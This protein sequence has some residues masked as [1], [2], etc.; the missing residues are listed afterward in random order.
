[1]IA[2]LRFVMINNQQEGEMERK[3]ENLTSLAIMYPGKV[4]ME[5]IIKGISIFGSFNMGQERL[6]PTG[7][8]G[9]FTGPYPA[10]SFTH[11]NGKA[12]WGD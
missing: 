6:K 9:A 1:M 3:H 10:A 2:S 12:G 8:D 7:Y 4:N 11:C 5:M